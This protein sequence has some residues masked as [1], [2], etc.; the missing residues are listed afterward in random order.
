MADVKQLVSKTDGTKTELGS[1]DVLLFPKIESSPAGNPAA[2]YSYFYI[3]EDG[4]YEKNSAGIVSKLN[5]NFGTT[6]GTVAEGNDSRILNGQTAFSWGSHIAENYVHKSGDL[7]SGAI[8]RT[9]TVAGYQVGE[10]SFTGTNPIYVIGSGYI[11]N[12]TT[13]GDMYGIGFTHGSAPFINSTNLGT[14]ASGWGMYFATAGVARVFIEG[15]AGNIHSKGNVYSQN[16]IFRGN[17]TTINDSFINGLRIGRGASNAAENTAIG[18]SALN[19]VITGINNTAVGSYALSSNIEGHNNS[20]FGFQALRFNLGHNNSAFGMFALS[21]N[22]TG[23]TNL[24]VGSYALSVN[25]I[26]NNNTSTGNS[27]LNANT[28]GNNNTAFGT[29]T[30]YSN[31][32]G[33]NNTAIGWQSFLNINT[34]SNNTALGYSTGWG[35]TTGGNNTILGAN[36]TGLASNLENNIILANGNGLIKAQHDG[37]DWVFTGGLNVLGRVKNIGSITAA[38]G[39]AIGTTI[40]PTL[41]AAANNN[42]LTAI[43]IA[44]GYTNGAFTGVTNYGIRSTGKI[45]VTNNTNGFSADNASI[46]TVGGIYA[47]NLCQFNGGLNVLDG[48][49]NGGFKSNSIFAKNASALANALTGVVINASMTATSGTTPEVR[50][51][52]ITPTSN[53]GGHTMTNVAGLIIN[54][55]TVGVNNTQLLLGNTTPTG[56]W[57]I[58]SSST[59]ASYLAT[60]LQIGST[61]NQGYTGLEITGTSIFTGQQTFKGTTSS[62]GGVLGSELLA[63]GSGTNWTGSGFATGYTHTVGSIATLTNSFVPFNNVRYYIVTTVTGRTAGSFTIDFGGYVTNS[64]TASDIRA[65]ITTSTSTL[66]ITPTTDFDGTIVLSIKL[67]KEGTATISLLNSAGTITNEIKA[68]LNAGNVSLGLRSLNSIIGSG[69][70]NNTAIGS[71][72]LMLNVTG[73]GNSALGYRSLGSNISG[74]YNIGVGYQAM[75]SN[76]IGSYN[77]AVG[78]Q[79]LY[80]NKSGTNNIAIGYE[81]MLN[82]ITGS[83]NTAIGYWSLKNNTTG[84]YNTATGFESLIVNTTGTGNTSYGFQSLWSNTTGTYNS[85]HGYRALFYNTTGLSNTAMGREALNN[86]TTGNNNT[87]I[88]NGTGLGITTGSGN[89]ILGAGVTGLASGL[90]NNIILANGV[91]AIKAQHDGTDWVFTGSVKSSTVIKLKNYTVSTLPTG[92]EGDTAYVTDATTPTYLG[93]LTGGGSIKCPVFYNGTAWVSH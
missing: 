25:T 27:S 4:I 10:F 16:G 85:A 21:S 52:T 11:P 54:N 32:S 82:N 89:T 15:D 61:T 73:S 40:S 1:S 31:I 84:T 72:S 30:L 43:D 57:G 6:A 48:S 37:T 93:T 60:K 81:S 3:L 90:T 46:G 49:Q 59:Y 75:F 56:N 18:D 91:G 88:G 44:A 76:S 28:I 2:G 39:S 20:A 29:A 71:F 22:T 87:A 86:V 51:M 64:I 67:A 8:G 45:Y 77:T 34:G 47:G 24:A 41:I 7:M 38:S 5:N 12:S 83:D 33:N 68:H 70:V 50:G 23:G 63:T 79:S 66:V 74:S 62:D 55:Q 78:Y 42:V 36:V 69:V 26:G 92:V 14:A 13:L 58:Y 80:Y 53:S 19:Y 9:T 17:I 65:I 35:I